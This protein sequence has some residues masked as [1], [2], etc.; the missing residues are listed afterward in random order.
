M[1]GR[2][3]LIITFSPVCNFAVCTCATEADARGDESNS[4]KASL[5]DMSSSFS[6]M[7]RAISLEKGGTLSCNF[8]SSFA[9]S[10]GS[11]SLR[12]DKA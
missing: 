6:I 11:I 12:V 9:M 4:A 10:S 1:S 3:T 5:I 7:L 2:K 8:T